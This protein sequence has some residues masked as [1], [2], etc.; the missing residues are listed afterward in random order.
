MDVPRLVDGIATNG[1]AMGSIRRAKRKS[2]Q[3][4]SALSGVSVGYLS[5]LERGDKGIVARERLLAVARA[6]D[7]DVRALT[8]EPQLFEPEEAAA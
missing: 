5:D 7:V 6:L 1:W 4:V 8:T 2:L 3:D